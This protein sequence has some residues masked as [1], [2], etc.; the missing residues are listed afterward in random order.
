MF[1]T[2]AVGGRCVFACEYC[3][4]AKATYRLNWPSDPSDFVVGDVCR[5]SPAT[6]P[7]ADVL[8]AGFPCQVSLTLTSALTLTLSLTLSL[9]L[10]LSLALEP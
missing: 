10:S 9:S 6:I 2:Q 1:W 4:F 7:P 3:K 5:Q 8:V